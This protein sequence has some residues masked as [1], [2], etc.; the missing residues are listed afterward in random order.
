MEFK[1]EDPKER[2]LEIATM[3]GGFDGSHH[4]DWVIDQM[5]RALTGCPIVAEVAKDYRGQEY[6]YEA[7]GESEAYKAFVAYAKA[8]GD[9]PETY[10]WKVGTPP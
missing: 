6:Q 8:G 7:Q 1:S 9:G 4:K 2:A 10:E 5:I 3:Y